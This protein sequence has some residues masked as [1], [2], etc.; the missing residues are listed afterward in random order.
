MTQ[1]IA[2]RTAPM[3]LVV[4]AALGTAAHR[5]VSKDGTSCLR[6]PVPS[7]CATARLICAP[8]RERVHGHRS[9][10]SAVRSESVAVAWRRAGALPGLC[11]APAA[12]PDRARCGDLRAAPSRSDAVL[13][14][15]LP[16]RH[17]R[18]V[19]HDGQWPPALDLPHPCLEGRRRRQA[20]DRAV[21]EPARHQGSR[22]RHE[23]VLGA[24]AAG[25]GRLRT[26]RP[27][28]I[29]SRRSVPTAPCASP[30]MPRS[31]PDG[32]EPL[33]AHH[34]RPQLAQGAGVFGPAGM[35]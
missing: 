5:F 29:R 7:L 33:R 14:L 3:L 10:R 13:P 23:P 28:P 17:V 26:D 6:R 16:G 31:N 22:H 27:A 35:R 15:C 20:G 19:R 11:G 12:E 8:V 30:P 4:A 34:I 2:P 1:F 25:Q 18:V 9:N 24:L 21:G 32:G